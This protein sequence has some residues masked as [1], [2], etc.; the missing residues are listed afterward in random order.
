MSLIFSLITI[1]IISLGSLI[2]II[3]NSQPTKSFSIINIGFYLFVLL[4]LYSSISLLYFFFNQKNISFR[5]FFNRRILIISLLVSGFIIMSSLQVLSII[6]AI[7]FF[8][9]MILLEL[10]FISYKGHEK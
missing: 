8:I 2:V 1:L 6:S 10:F 3:S 5:R 7:S 9:S 4:F